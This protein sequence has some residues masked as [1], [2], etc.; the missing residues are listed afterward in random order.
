[1][2]DRIVLS[3][4]GTHYFLAGEEV[5]EAAY[6]AVYP[7]PEAGQAP[8]ASVSCSAWPLISDALA[9]HPKQVAE[10]NARNRKAGVHVTYQADG[11]AVLPDR[12]ERRKLLRLEGCHDKQ[13]GYSD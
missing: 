5:T 9:V 11:R 4:D 8:P 6:R 3:K 13:G 2:K 7:L 10:A 12:N 1:M